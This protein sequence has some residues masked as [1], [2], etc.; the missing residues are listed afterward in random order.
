MRINNTDL[1]SKLS[2]VCNDIFANYDSDNLSTYEKRKLIF[3][4]LC[5][6]LEYDWNL[7]KDIE[8]FFEELKKTQQPVKGFSRDSVKELHDTVFNHKGIC[9]G[10]AQYYKLLLQHMNVYSVQICCDDGT[11]VKHALNLVYDEENDTY[12]LDDVTGFIVGRGSKDDFFDYDIED[13]NNMNQ[14]L[15]PIYDNDNWIIIPSSYVSFLAN[16]MDNKFHQKFD[17]ERD[18]SNIVVPKN[19]K[20]IKKSS[21]KSK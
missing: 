5:D 7:Y 12:S 14:G 15:K 17:L 18:E 21:N 20:S 8:N 13:A 1:N 2:N 3:N 6:N 16:D 4:Y 10:I 19:I 9:N 11:S